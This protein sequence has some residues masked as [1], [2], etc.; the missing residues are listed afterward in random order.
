MADKTLKTA[1]K[2][3]TDKNAKFRI[4]TYKREEKEQ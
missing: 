1:K 3:S 4:S 2:V